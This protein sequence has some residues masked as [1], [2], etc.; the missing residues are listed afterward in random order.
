MCRIYYELQ[1]S[2]VMYCPGGWTLDDIWAAT[3]SL[4]GRGGGAKI[5]VVRP[6]A[7]A[8]EDLCV[9]VYIHIYIY[10]YIHTHMYSYVYSYVYI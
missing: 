10:I 7:G 9:C 3:L 6:S 4:G 2:T 1:D 8:S 5:Y